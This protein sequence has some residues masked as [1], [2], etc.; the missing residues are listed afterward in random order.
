MQEHSGTRVTRT[1]EKGG[2]VRA[3][4]LR[5]QAVVLILV[6]FIGV[7]LSI[8]L[9]VTIRRTESGRA[10]IVF[11]NAAKERLSVL[12]D[13]I[14][15]NLQTLDWVA[16]FFGRSQ[17]VERSE[18]REFTR[19]YLENHH[20]VRVV[21]WIPLVQDTDRAAYETAVRDDDLSSFQ[22]T[23]RWKDG[24]IVRAT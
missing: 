19:A 15:Q 1:R 5:H 9:Y 16:G 23:E 20:E 2:F 22:I 13:H 3:K 17:K 24:E 7:L 14:T 21:Q 4:L 6:A 10:E 12:K 8:L 11:E 18:F